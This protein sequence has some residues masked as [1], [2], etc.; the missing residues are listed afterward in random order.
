MRYVQ[1]PLTGAG[2]HQDKLRLV[3]SSNAV[4]VPPDVID[5][6]M[7]DDDRDDDNDDNGGVV[8]PPVK[9]KRY[10][11]RPKYSKFD[12]HNPTGLLTKPKP[13]YVIKPKPLRK[14]KVIDQRPFDAAASSTSNLRHNIMGSQYDL[15]NASRYCRSFNDTP[16]QTPEKKLVLANQNVQQH[17]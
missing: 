9:V 3:C 12:N 4:E 16:P 11:P 2:M 8:A 17:G 6:T 5:L 14:A 7:D 10:N 1:R 15:D 13:K